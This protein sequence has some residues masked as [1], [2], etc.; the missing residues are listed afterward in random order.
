MVIVV[1]VA[2]WLPEDRRRPADRL[3]LQTILDAYRPLMH[4]LS[5]R[6]LY[7]CTVLRSTCWLGLLTYFGALLR[8]RFGLSMSEVGLVYMLGGSGYLL[9]SLVAGGPFARLPARPLVAISNVTM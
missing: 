3:R 7:A 6:S 8:D 4:D 5:M 2:A 9:G 1:L